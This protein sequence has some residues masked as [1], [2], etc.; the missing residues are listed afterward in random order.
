MWTTVSRLPA[1]SSEGT[2]Q[3]AH[4]SLGTLRLDSTDLEAPRAAACPR[5]QCEDG[6]GHLLAAII[7]VSGS[8]SQDGLF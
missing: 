2:S 8:F 6:P 1:R 5:G 4:P 3:G 7:A